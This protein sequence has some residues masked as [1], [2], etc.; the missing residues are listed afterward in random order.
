MPSMTS[1]GTMILAGMTT[2]SSGAFK[3]PKPALPRTE[4]DSS[5]TA[6]K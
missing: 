6:A 4:N 3:P 5:M 1:A 2:I